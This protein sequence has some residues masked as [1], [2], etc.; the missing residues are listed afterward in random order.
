MEFLSALWMPILV[1][2]VLVWIASF[3]T[4]MVLPIHKGEWQGL[5]G[6]AKAME[7]LAGTAPGNYMMPWGTM[8]D[9]KNPEFVEKQKLGPTGTVIVWPGPVNMGRNLVLT[10]LSYWVIGLFVAYVCYF[11]FLGEPRP[12]YLQIFRIAGAAAFM[13]HGLGL[14]PHAIWYRGIRLWSVLLEALI[15]AAIT[16]GTFGWLWP[17]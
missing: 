16:A 9:M 5:P 8:A 13:T 2:G 12:H 4:H 10:L 14:I 11:A 3:L 1:S 17:K 6:E 15:F 7:A